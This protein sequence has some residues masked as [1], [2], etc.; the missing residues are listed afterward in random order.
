MSNNL[1]PAVVFAALKFAAA[2]HRTQKRKDH[3]G[4]PYINHPIDVAEILIRVAGVDDT[5]TIAAALLHDTVEDT[6]TTAEELRE[7]FGEDITSL[8]LEC[9]DDKSLPKAERKRLQ[10]VN[11]SHK[12][13]RARLIKIADKISN[14]GDITKTPP[15]DWSL[16]RKVEYIDWAE[17]VVAG[18]RGGCSELD[19]LF[20]Q[21]IK[22]ARIDMTVGTGGLA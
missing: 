15:P 10:V 8:V 7:L 19:E 21:K 3:D 6:G 5:S 14:I 22:V 17:K 1:D 16:E 20:D 9:T 11:A 13:P 4:S 18:L 2:K 12:T